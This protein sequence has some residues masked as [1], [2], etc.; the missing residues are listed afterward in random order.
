MVNYVFVGVFFRV[1][2]MVGHR[3]RVIAVFKTQVAWL[4]PVAALEVPEHGVPLRGGVIEAG[5]KS[6]LLNGRR[7]GVNVLEE[8][9]FCGTV[10]TAP[11]SH[12]LARNACLC[13]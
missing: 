7:K 2:W 4:D 13:R 3:N 1:T 9:L 12:Y 11:G 6:V 8:V 5:I 10:S